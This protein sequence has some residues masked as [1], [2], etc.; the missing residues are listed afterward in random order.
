MNGDDGYV[1]GGGG[2]SVWWETGISEGQVYSAEVVNLNGHTRRKDGHTAYRLRGYD[3][4]TERRDDGRPD[5]RGD[6]YIVVTITD[7]EDIRRIEF[8]GRALRLYLPIETRDRDAPRLRQ[9]SVRW[10]LRKV[11]QQLLD[12]AKVRAALIAQGAEE[13][14]GPGEEVAREIGSA[15]AG[16]R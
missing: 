7:V 15:A 10:G 16:P 12:W 13:S 2:G 1:D 5:P 8:V 4:F 11:A 6:G 3:S 14:A 9:F